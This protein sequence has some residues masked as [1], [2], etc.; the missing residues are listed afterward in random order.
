MSMIN[1]RS[2]ETTDTALRNLMEITGRERAD[3]VRTAIVDAERAAIRARARAEALAIRDD[4]DDRAEVAAIMAEMD[5][6][7]A[8]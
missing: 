3:A 5:A 1:V 4:P 8:W 2:N 6:V 7:R